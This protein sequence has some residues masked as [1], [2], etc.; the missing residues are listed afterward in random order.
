M[1][2]NSRPTAQWALVLWI[3]SLLTLETLD[4]VAM[5]AGWLATALM[6][7]AAT[8]LVHGGALAFELATDSYFLLSRTFVNFSSTML[9]FMR[10]HLVSLTWGLVVGAAVIDWGR[11]FDTRL[12]AFDFWDPTTLRLLSVDFAISP[13]YFLASVMLVMFW[14][15][16]LN[17]SY[18]LLDDENSWTLFPLSLLRQSI[19]FM[20]GKSGRGGHGRGGGRGGAQPGGNVVVIG[21]LPPPPPW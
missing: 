21:A 12:F 17:D 14:A 1:R 7:E 20:A 11:T 6:E 2:P 13:T 15:I 4:S 3:F 5:F 9:S 19:L 8:W 10:A 18:D 16:L